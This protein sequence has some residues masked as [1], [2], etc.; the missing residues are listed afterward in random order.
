MEIVEILEVHRRLRAFDPAY[1]AD[2]V[3]AQP[4]VLP[5]DEADAVANDE[6]PKRASALAPDIV[7]L[8]TQQR[9]LR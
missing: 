6:T 2:S 5:A 8:I 3:G 7:T 1:A 9:A 4:F